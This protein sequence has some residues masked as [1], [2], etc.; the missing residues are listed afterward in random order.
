MLT[1]AVVTRKVCGFA[2]WSG[3]I[4]VKS[5]KP[6]EKTNVG[7]RVVLSFG[8]RAWAGGWQLPKVQHKMQCFIGTS[9]ESVGKSR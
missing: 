3:E 5:E 1:H 4:R 7:G 9:I 8:F 6:Q 2:V